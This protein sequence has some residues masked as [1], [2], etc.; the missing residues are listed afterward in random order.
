MWNIKAEMVSNCSRS[1]FSKLR[2]YNILGKIHNNINHTHN[3]LTHVIN[4]Y[5]H[6]NIYNVTACMCTLYGISHMQYI[7]Y[8]R[9]LVI[10]N[11]IIIVDVR[12]SNSMYIIYVCDYA[13]L[14]NIV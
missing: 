13:N 4:Q 1:Y 3:E 8:S 12:T 10:L 14:T 7:V 11:M 2:S 9:V 6:I 5:V